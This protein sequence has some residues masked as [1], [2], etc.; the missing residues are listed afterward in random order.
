MRRNIIETIMGAAV[1][2]VAVGFVVFAF[3]STGMGSVDGYRVSASFDD[4][5]GVSPGTDVRM[6]GVKIGSVVE[7]KL[8]TDTY[9]AEITMA[10]DEDVTLPTDTS[11]RIVPES[12]LGGNYVNLEPGG[13][14]KSIPEGGRIEY[15]QG[16]VNLI[17]LVAKFMFSDG[18]GGS[19]AGSGSSPGDDSQN[20]GV[21]GG[22][23]VPGVN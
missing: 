9:F 4:V 5:T 18:Q 11:A 15:T 19:G 12:L 6:S 1:L 16:A 21:P 2:V 10:I 20:G 13:A 17:D 23:G 7:Q 14:M 8:D 22:S 3:S